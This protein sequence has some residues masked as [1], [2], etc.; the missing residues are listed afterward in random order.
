MN[1]KATDLLYWLELLLFVFTALFFHLY[2]LFL[3][4]YNAEAMFDAIG[5]FVGW[6][7]T[8]KSAL[9]TALVFTLGFLSVLPVIL[10]IAGWLYVWG[11]WADRLMLLTEPE[12]GQGEQ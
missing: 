7:F 11:L 12:N 4:I 3:F 5:G 1:L 8:E 6:L 2:L 9:L 10:A